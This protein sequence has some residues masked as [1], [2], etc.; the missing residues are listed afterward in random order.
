[1]SDTT[2][3][4]HK[5]KRN[6]PTHLV[7]FKTGRVAYFIQEDAREVSSLLGES[8]STPHGYDEV[9]FDVQ[10]LPEILS[11]LSLLK[12]E[13]V[14]LGRKPNAPLRWIP[15]SLEPP[16]DI[17]CFLSA[18]KERF[19]CALEE[20]KNGKMEERV[21]W[22]MFPRMVG[23]WIDES[24]DEGKG[25]RT[26]REARMVLRKKPIGENLRVVTNALLNFKK[27]ALRKLGVECL[28]HIKACATLFLSL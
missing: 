7:V 26:L 4:Y 14:G 21:A 1:M 23:S 16:S 17:S 18:H 13:C 5:S 12:H 15:C 20:F 11:R 9:V 8:I 10:R 3:A 2:D 28:S 27:S 6:H 24:L 22:F 19:A 25:L